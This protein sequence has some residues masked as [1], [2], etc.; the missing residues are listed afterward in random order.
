MDK[1]SLLK[2]ALVAVV[3]SVFAAGLL[4]FILPSEG[5]GTD[6]AELYTMLPLAKIL[7]VG[8]IGMYAGKFAYLEF[9]K[10]PIGDG[11]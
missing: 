3:I 8:A 6:F 7:I 11:K 4:A 5:S 1:V 2:S 10:Q 9:E